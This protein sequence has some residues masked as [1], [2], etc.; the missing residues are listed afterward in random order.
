MQYIGR[1]T[2]EACD[3]NHQVEEGSG[4]GVSFGLW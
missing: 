2:P 3:S 4:T 1:D